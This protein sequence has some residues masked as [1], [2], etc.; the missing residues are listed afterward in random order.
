[1]INLTSNTG[2][3]TDSLLITSNNN[4]NNHNKNINN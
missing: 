4:N 3:Q 2:N 1:M